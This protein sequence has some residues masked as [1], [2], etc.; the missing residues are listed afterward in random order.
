M[1]VS[2]K[3]ATKILTLFQMP[4]LYWDSIQKMYT[5]VFVAKIESKI[6]LIFQK[7]KIATS[8]TLAVKFVKCFSEKIKTQDKK[9]DI[10]N[11]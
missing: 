11:W 4:F 2:S 7:R 8:S 5:L 6:L 1:F 9:K 3:N 10:L